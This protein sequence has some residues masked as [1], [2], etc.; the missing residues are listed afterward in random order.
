MDIK[1]Y[2]VKRKS[3]IIL[4]GMLAFVLLSLTGCHK[5]EQITITSA[6]IESV[7]MNGMKAVDVTMKIMIDNPA[8]KVVVDAAEGVVKHFGKVIGT[9]TLAPMTLMPRRLAE[10]QAQAHVELAPGI[11]ILEVLSLANPKK[12]EEMVVDLSFSGRVAGVKIKKTITDVPLKKLLEKTIN[13]K[14]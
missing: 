8:G 2:K 3:L 1:G 13:E 5:Y 9:A 14:N 7:Q 10:Y 4:I 11:N 6:E 12:I